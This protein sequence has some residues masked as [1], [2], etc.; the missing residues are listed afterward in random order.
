MVAMLA[1][2]YWASRKGSQEDFLIADRKLSPLSAGISFAVTWLEA[3][4]IFFIIALGFS[5]HWGVLWALLAATVEIALLGVVAPRIR[6]VTFKTKAY[7]LSELASKTIGNFSGLVS[8]FIILVGYFLWTAMSIYGGGQILAILTG[9]S[10]EIC[11]VL[12]SFAAFSYL[13]LGGFKASIY[14][15]VFQYSWAII[16]IIALLIFGKGAGE[17]ADLS[18]VKGLFEGDWKASVWMIPMFILTGTN[19]FGAIARLIASESPSSARKASFISLFAQNI[20]LLIFAYLGYVISTINP[21]LTGDDI[22]FYMLSEYMPAYI[23]PLTLIAFLGIVISSVDTYLLVTSH[24]LM[25]DCFMMLKFFNKRDYRKMLRWSLLIC[26]VISTSVA[27]YISQISTLF[28]LGMMILGC[29]A[30]IFLAGVFEQTKSKYAAGLVS[31]FSL[32]SHLVLYI[33]FS[34]TESTSVIMNLSAIVIWFI[35]E[36]ILGCCES[37]DSK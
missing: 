5:V 22:S 4:Y 10:F 30:P 28:T 21:N 9:L 35:W 16:L 23:L 27:I 19:A 36:K 31:L 29:G 7:N 3:P 12:I 1:I 24:A 8:A 6:E 11:A 17:H 32:I 37:K 2:G 25:D 15:D 18:Q 14:T 34:I 20:P 13:L 33:S 26:A